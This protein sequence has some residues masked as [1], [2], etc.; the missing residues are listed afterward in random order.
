MARAL[1]ELNQ[2]GLL[3]GDAAQGMFDSV[4]I[5]HQDILTHRDTHAIW[6]GIPYRLS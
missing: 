2:A 5:T 1:I 3:T 4:A 6:D